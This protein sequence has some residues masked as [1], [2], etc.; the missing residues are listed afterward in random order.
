MSRGQPS[1]HDV[2]AILEEA[3]RAEPWAGLVS[4]YLFGSLAEG[5]T[6]R[7]SDVDL[8]VL[9]DWDA[10]PT[11]AHRFEARVRL[12]GRLG[13]ALARSDVD[14]VV[15]NDAPP[16]LGRRI[17]TEGLRLVCTDPE[18]DHA[19]VRDVQLRAADVVPFLRRTAPLKL[20]AIR[21]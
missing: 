12:S 19:Y 10:F 20:A 9:L 5:R 6:H 7:E 2:R 3:L 18:A 15:L 1:Q 4:L 8:A 13:T 11:A 21:R 14:L 17:V 16:L